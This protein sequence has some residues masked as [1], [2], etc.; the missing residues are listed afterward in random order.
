MFIFDTTGD[1]TA[2]YDNYFFMIRR[3]EGPKR[4]SGCQGAAAR[5]QENTCT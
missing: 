5:A 4:G 1:F 3:V 2:F